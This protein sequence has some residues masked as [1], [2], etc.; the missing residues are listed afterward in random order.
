VHDALRECGYV[1]SHRLSDENVAFR[2]GSGS[3]WRARFR[4]VV[5]DPL[6][7]AIYDVRPLFDLRVLHGP[8]GWAGE[9]ESLVR[10]ER[11]HNPA[12]LQV[13]G[14]DCLAH[15]PPLSFYRDLVVEDT[16][17]RRDVFHLERNALRPLVDVGRLFALA[18]GRFFAVSTLE[19]LDGSAAAFP[20]HAAVFRDAAD[21]FRVLLYQQA[22]SGISRHDGGTQIPPAALDGH[23]RQMLKT[24]FRGV[25][26]LLELAEEW[27]WPDTR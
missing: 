1:P 15:L 26:R 9:I 17:E 23:D 6:G 24:A 14:H 18:S 21:A 5:R 20:E 25:L 27:P 11:A 19:R 16:G 13:L 4:D 8:S 10:E 2:C 3:A 7:A 22:R 12:L